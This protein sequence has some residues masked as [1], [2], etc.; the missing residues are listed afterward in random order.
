MARSSFD[1]N[2]LKIDFNL[3]AK[4]KEDADVLWLGANVKDEIWRMEGFP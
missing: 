4:K 3:V 2:K 1:S